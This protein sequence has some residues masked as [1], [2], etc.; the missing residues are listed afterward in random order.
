[1]ME[2]PSAL[3]FTIAVILNYAGMLLSVSMI[4]SIL[5]IISVLRVLD[6]EPLYSAV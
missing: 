5:L 4:V 2:L 1:M 6:I 3:N